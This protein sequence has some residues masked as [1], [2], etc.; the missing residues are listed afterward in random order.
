MLMAEHS[1]GRVIRDLNGCAVDVDSSRARRSVNVANTS[2]RVAISVTSI[3]RGLAA[4]AASS[5]SSWSGAV[6]MERI[7]AVAAA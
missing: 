3:R 5:Q 7:A 1:A 4:S 6:E 2:A